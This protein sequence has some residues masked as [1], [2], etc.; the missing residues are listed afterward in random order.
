MNQRYN[1]SRRP[2]RV[3]KQ[4]VDET[5]NI[6]LTIT[7]DNKKKYIACGIGLFIFSFIQGVLVG[8]LTSKEQ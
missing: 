5:K 2:Y 8:I 1:Q 7:K 4:Q 3:A 6:C